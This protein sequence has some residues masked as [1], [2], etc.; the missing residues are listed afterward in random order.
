MAQHEKEKNSTAETQEGQMAFNQLLAYRTENREWQKESFLIGLQI[1]EALDQKNWTKKELAVAMNV[2]PQIVQT[3]LS[4]TCEF[5][6]PLKHKLQ[7]VLG[8]R[9]GDAQIS[10]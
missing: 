7:R 9:L 5:G 2:S 8:V 6:L 10:T 3:Y 1:L 4:G